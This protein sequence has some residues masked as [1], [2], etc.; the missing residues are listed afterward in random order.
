MRRVCLWWV[1]AG[2]L[3]TLVHAQSPQPLGDVARVLRSAPREHAAR[4]YDNDTI[5]KSDKLNAVGA[6]ESAATSGT[7]IETEAPASAEK[8]DS[9]AEKQQLLVSDLDAQKKQMELLSR[10]LDVLNREYRLRAAS[11]YADAGNRLRDP[12]NW[13]KEDA[14]FKQQIAAKQKE[15]DSAK[16]HLEDV[17]EQAR[18]AGV[19]AKLR[20]E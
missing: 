8:P 17:Q 14:Q 20:G 9:R 4:T 18:K 19:P 12:T 11:Y 16:Q 10:E 5:P 1:V 6:G 13:D 2:S 7:D 3:L 15:L